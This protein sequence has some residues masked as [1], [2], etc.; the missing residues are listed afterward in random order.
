MNTVEWLLDSDHA[1]RW[2]AMTEVSRPGKRRVV[3]R[4]DLQPSQTETP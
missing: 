3:M 2:Q 4:I 1:I